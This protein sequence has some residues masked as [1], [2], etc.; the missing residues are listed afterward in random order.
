[1]ALIPNNV[2]TRETE[3]EVRGRFGIAQDGKPTDAQLR[4]QVALKGHIAD[5]AVLINA[6]IE[7][8]REK[9]LAITHLEEA[10]MWAG[11]A[12]FR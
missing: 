5:I 7:D 12:I 2:P 4:E 10:L 6:N 3:A 9:S 1:M 8:S 11:K